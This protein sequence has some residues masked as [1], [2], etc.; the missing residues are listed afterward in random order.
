MTSTRPAVD[1]C[2]PQC[3]TSLVT[4]R[5]ATAWCPSCEW[6]LALVEPDRP[7]YFGWRWL[8]RVANR[9]AHRLTRRQF[10]SLVGRPV[11][12]SGL[13]VTRVLVGLAS[14]LLYAFMAGLL[15]LGGWLI[16]YDFPNL[17]IVPG[18]LVVLVAL[19][20]RPRFGRLAR[21]SVTLSRD[22]A[23]EFFGL[24][25]R[26][27]E[28]LGAARPHVV[29]INHG[30]NA[31]AGAVGLRR[32]RVI[33]LGIPLFTL[34]P[35]DQR[36]ALLGHELG[37]FV[38]GDVR[39]GLLVQPAYTTLGALAGLLQPGGGTPWGNGLIER[40][41]TLVSNAVLAVL[42]RLAMLAQL[43]LEALALRDSQ[44]AEYLADELAATAGGTRG[45]VDLLH[46]LLGLDSI[47]LGV[48]RAARNGGDAAEWQAAAEE[49]RTA[50]TPL[51]PVLGQLSV[52]EDTGLFASHPPTGLRV[53]MIVSRPYQ[54]PRV[55]L[56]PAGSARIDA[57][58]APYVAKMRKEV[59]WEDLY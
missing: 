12:R 33:M 26:L 37:H 43:F 11:G 9:I 16:A 27:V 32:R 29:V 3:G 2:C 46:T 36:V 4:A 25:D 13:N 34:L 42:S 7:G 58:L 35:A 21:H 6:N 17:A 31:S 24:V 18:V 10:G 20:I 40:L 8:D 59:G 15:V 5:G 48:R 39:R 51:M 30:F 14:L 1:G 56:S 53:R 49:A 44:R 55:A 57:E 28:A 38:N 23:P 50:V 52:R 45:A 22:R 41:I 47:A 54:T 19:A